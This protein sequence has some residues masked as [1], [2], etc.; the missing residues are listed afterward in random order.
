VGIAGGAMYTHTSRRC[1]ARSGLADGALARRRVVVRHPLTA[2]GNGETMRREGHSALVHTGGGVESGQSSSISASRTGFRW[3][4]VVPQARHQE[5]LS[6]PLGAV[7][8]CNSA[9]AVRSPPI[10]VGGPKAT[11]ATLAFR[12]HG[13]RHAGKSDPNGHGGSGQRDRRGVLPLWVDRAQAVYTYG[14][15]DTSPTILTRNFGM[16]WGIGGGCSHRPIV[17]AGAETIARLQ[18]GWPP[19]HHDVCR[20]YTREISLAGM[21]R[22]DAFNAYV[23]RATGEKFLVTPQAAT[24]TS[25]PDEHSY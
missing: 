8:T 17:S 13:R 25:T 22:P 10:F 21:L 15:L 5:E 18:P 9:V 24:G 16:A 4:T 20:T 3:S 12:R 11:S 6:D 19:N 2:L 14:G 23:K 7:Y 1:P